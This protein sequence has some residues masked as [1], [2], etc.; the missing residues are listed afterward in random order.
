MFRRIR[1]AAYSAVSNVIS[2]VASAAQRRINSFTNWLTSYVEPTQI[3]EVLNEVT[4]HVR[5]NYPPLQE[6]RSALRKFTTQ[7]TIE[8]REGYE[9]QS[10]LREVRRTVTNL[11]RNNRRTKVKLIL[12]CNMERVSILSED[13]TITD[14]AAF[15]SNVEVNLEGTDVNDLY[16]TMVDRN[17]EAMAAF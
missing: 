14:S 7:Y 10:F 8:G 9:P 5:R 12:R 13:G 2:S 1:N 11:L 3:G 4:E 16:N 6:S 15:H 17:L